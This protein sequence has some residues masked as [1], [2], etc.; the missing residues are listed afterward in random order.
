MTGLLIKMLWGKIFDY[1]SSSGGVSAS[2]LGESLKGGAK[3]K[4]YKK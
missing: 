4:K 1:G 3:K 2:S